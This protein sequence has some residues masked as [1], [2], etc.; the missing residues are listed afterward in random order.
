MVLDNNLE[1]AK[2]IKIPNIITKNIAKVEIIVD[3][4]PKFVPAINIEAIVIK[5]GN[6]PVTR[7]KI[8]C[9]YRN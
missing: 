8:I 6:I 1:M 4:T 7:D 2:V 3:Q 9:K 5:K